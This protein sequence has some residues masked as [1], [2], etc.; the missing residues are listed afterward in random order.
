MT[1]TWILMLFLATG[2][3]AVEP[4]ESPLACD[5]DRAAIAAAA[6]E[7]EAAGMCPAVVAAICVAAWATDE[8]HGTTEG[9]E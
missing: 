7:T 9:G 8:F 3:I 2:E 4:R 1:E 6:A 5:A